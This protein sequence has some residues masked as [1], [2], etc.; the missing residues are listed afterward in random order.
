[1]RLYIQL[2]ENSLVRKV[3][4]NVLNNYYLIIERKRVFIYCHFCNYILS[5][6]SFCRQ[7]ENINILLKTELNFFC[8]R[9]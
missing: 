3:P 5:F 4:K 8:K 1:M 7:L 2:Y 6:V 9:N